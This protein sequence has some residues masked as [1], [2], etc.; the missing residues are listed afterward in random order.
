MSAAAIPAQR[1]AITVVIGAVYFVV[2]GVIAVWATRRTRTGD[3]FFVAGSGIGLWTMTLSAMAA[4]LSGFIFIGGPGLLYTVGFGALFISLSASI[5]TPVSA[6]LLAVP[7]RA[8]RDTHGAITVP[9]AVGIR[10]GSR[11]AQGICAVAIVVAT[12]GYVATN[13]LALGVVVQAI[14]PL[15]LPVATVTG[16]GVV[17]AY[18]VTGGILAGVYTDVFQGSIKAVASVLVFVAVLRAGH[19]LGAISH[20]LLARDAAFIGPWGTMTPLAA[21]SL[22]FLFGVGT[23]GQPQVIS[24]YYM[25]RDPSQLRWYP[26][27][28]TLILIVTLLLFFG[29]GIGV[30]AAVLRGAIAPLARADDATPVFLMTQTAPWLAAIVF[31]GIAA[32]IMGTVNAFFNVGGAALAHDL[33]VALGCPVRNE[34][35]VGRW[36]TLVI[37]AASAALAMQS[38]A[39]VALLGIFGWG[40]FASTLVPSLAIGINWRGATAAG[41]VWS[42]VVGLVVTLVAESANH[43]GWYPLPNGVNASGLALVLAILTLFVVSWGTGRGRERRAM[44]CTEPGAPTRRGAGARLLSVGTQPITR[45]ESPTGPQAI[46]CPARVP[47]ALRMIKLFARTGPASRR[48]RV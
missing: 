18:S 17:V 43:F 9:D 46:R 47:P 11:L 36:A 1:T 5:T 4:S 31:S 41:A 25:L 34:L 2:C 30:K 14:F 23:L 7:L 22:F 28:M 38:G 44:R 37:A 8:L 33:P 32:A 27:L 3:D 42:M 6:W 39:V 26:L 12:V 13:F 20:T 48:L 24:K 19:G 35:A 40:L 45:C 15:S 21:L 29:V 16:V 10:Y